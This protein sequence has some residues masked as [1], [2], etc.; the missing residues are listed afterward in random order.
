MERNYGRNIALPDTMQHQH[1]AN[2]AAAQEH[3]N[4]KIQ[5][6]W[7]KKGIDLNYQFQKNMNQ[8]AYQKEKSAIQIEEDVQKAK[9]R[10][11]ISLEKGL[12]RLEVMVLADGT[13]RLEQQRFGEPLQGSVPFR[14]K[15][16]KRFLPIFMEH[17]GILW[18]TFETKKYVDIG[19]GLDLEEV[20]PRIINRKFTA[21][22]LSFGFGGH[23]ETQLRQRLIEQAVEQSEAIRLPDDHGWYCLD[24][25][26]QFAFPDELTWKEVCTYAR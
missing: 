16:C 22:G 7:Q 11:D 2:L 26:L 20:S 10:A 18:L 12:K 17:S 15:S 25:K 19:F 4:L 21:L 8:V 1:N 3:S 24:G 6:H 14:V 23:R 5:E 9:A 13:L